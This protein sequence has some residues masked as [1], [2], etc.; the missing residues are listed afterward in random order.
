[1]K[2][3]P[4]VENLTVRNTDD[5]IVI[6]ESDEQTS[7][8]KETFITIYKPDQHGYVARFRTLCNVEK[9][10]ISRKLRW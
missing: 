7:C 2:D 6:I 1:V 3:N 5:D 4:A 8:L 9:Q 10:H